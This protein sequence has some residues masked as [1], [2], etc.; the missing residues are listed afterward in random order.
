MTFGF[1][2]FLIGKHV[3]AKIYK[4]VTCPTD[5]TVNICIGIAASTNAF[6][7]QYE[8]K[9]FDDI[10]STPINSI[11]CIGF[12]TFCYTVA[13]SIVQD[14]IQLTYKLPISMIITGLNVYRILYMCKINNK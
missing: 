7:D 13:V 1:N 14:N 2:A 9:S 4:H 5:K 10:V 3:F 6:A 12:S 8:K 11:V